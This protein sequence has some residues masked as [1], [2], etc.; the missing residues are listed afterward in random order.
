MME[1]LFAEKMKRFL[2]VFSLNFKSSFCWMTNIDL[3][4]LEIYM[5]ICRKFVFES[6]QVHSLQV[7]YYSSSDRVG[8]LTAVRMNAGAKLSRY[9]RRLIRFKQMDFEFAIWQMIYLLMKPQ[10][11]YR[12]FMYRKSKYLNFQ[13]FLL[14][15]V[16]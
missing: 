2:S 8:C 13:F 3:I 5:R 10:K 4:L 14:F 16:L 12:N 9:F 7:V 1:L 6:V 11:V 15:S